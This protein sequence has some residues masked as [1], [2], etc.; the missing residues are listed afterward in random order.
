MKYALIGSRAV[1]SSSRRAEPPDTE[2]CEGFTL[3]ETLIALVIL[4]FALQALYE[5]YSGGLRASE[6]ANQHEQ[7]RI[8]AASLLA[9]HTGDRSFKKQ[10]I[11]GRFENFSWRIWIDRASGINPVANPDPRWTLYWITADVSWPPNR[12]VQ[13]TTLRLGATNE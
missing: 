13:L 5:T 9:E 11:E 4:A 10:S 1:S 7:A 2:R 6:I 12:S 3:L 8:L